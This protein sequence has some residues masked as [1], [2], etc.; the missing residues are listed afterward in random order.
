MTI[1]VEHFQESFGADTLADWLCP[2]CSRGRL[3]LDKDSLDKRAT[4]SARQMGPDDYD[5]DLD[6]LSFSARLTCN[7]PACNESVFCIGDTAGTVE[8][9]DEF[10]DHAYIQVLRPKYLHPSPIV[11]VPPSKTPREVKAAISLASS[12]LWASTGAACNALRTSLELIMDDMKIPKQ[13]FNKRKELYDLKVHARVQEL[14]RKHSQISALLMAAKLVG[15][16]GSHEGDVGRSDAL[17]AFAFVDHV[18][19]YLYD[20]S[21]RTV[22]AQAKQRIHAEQLAKKAAK[23]AAKN[24]AVP[25]SKSKLKK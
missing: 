20:D 24:A 4:A 19:T 12:L 2:T 6:T 16:E 11:F 13:A 3:I 7:L 5:P 8:W 17:D 18:V 23:K 1:E 22:R 15:N 14:G 21:M 9:D 25:N 10:G